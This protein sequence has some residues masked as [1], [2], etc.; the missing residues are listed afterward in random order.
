MAPAQCDRNATFADFFANLR[1]VERFNRGNLSHW[2]AFH[3]LTNALE[4]KRWI[5]NGI[6]Y[7][8]GIVV[9]IGIV[10]SFLGLR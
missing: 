6:I 5:M 9:V 1:Y 3:E 7:L 8:V 4:R 2:I 10:L